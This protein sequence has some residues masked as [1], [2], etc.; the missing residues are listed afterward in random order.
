MSEIS[1][2]KII[3]LVEELKQRIK[4][5]KEELAANEMLTRYILIDPFLRALGWD[6]ENPK[7][8][9]PE[10][11]VGGERPDYALKFGETIK[12]F[13]EAKSLGGITDTV[14]I[15]KLKYSWQ[16]G[17]QY[18]IITDGNV[19][20]VFDAFKQVEWKDRKILEWN[21][22][23]E[24]PS[25]IAIKSLIIANTASFGEKSQKPI[26]VQ[27][28][29]ETPKES[30]SSIT[31]GGMERI[32]GPLT[33]PL[34][35]RLVLNVLANTTRPLRRREIVEE[36]GKRVELTPHDLEK[37]KS[38]RPRWEVTVRWVISILK[39]DKL[40]ESKGENQWVITEEGRQFL[41]R[42]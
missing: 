26:L 27:Q 39:M 11:Q 5:Y 8:V 12:A 34:A 17:I 37:T 22:E 13:V 10:P 20:M 24:N 2:T 29:I 15:D 18:T 41:T 4:K 16:T 42:E 3:N 33:D 31:Q 25:N 6:L 30:Q 21:V 7:Q 38:G 40:V 19:W 1:L 36:V 32:K 9:I 14:I 35:K 23:N 28:P